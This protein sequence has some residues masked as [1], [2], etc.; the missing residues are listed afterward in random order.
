MFCGIRSCAI[1]SV[2]GVVQ[3]VIVEVAIKAKNLGCQQILML[4]NC[5][6]QVQVV[7]KK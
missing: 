2:A 5:K 3:E 7:D 4:S 6:K 1:G